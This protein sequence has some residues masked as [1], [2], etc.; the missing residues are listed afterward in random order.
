VGEELLVRLARG[1]TLLRRA[2]GPV[3]EEVV[4]VE[5]HIELLAGC[6]LYDGCQDVQVLAIE[7][8][9]QWIIGPPPWHEAGPLERHPDNI[10]PERVDSLKVLRAGRK[11]VGIE[12]TWIGMSFEAPELESAQVDAAEDH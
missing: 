8:L 11:I 4:H 10:A 12:D 5:Y 2:A 3:L 6:A 1:D 7:S 9:G